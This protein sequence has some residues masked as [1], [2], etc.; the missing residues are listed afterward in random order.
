VSLVANAEGAQINES[1]NIKYKNVVYDAYFHLALTLEGVEEVEGDNNDV[2]IAV[3]KTGTSPANGDEPL[4]LSLKEYKDGNL[5]YYVTQGIAAKDI[6]VQISI[7]PVVVT[8]SGNVYGNCLEY[9]IAAYCQE[10]IDNDTIS[11]EQEALYNAT[12]AY[13]EAANAI[14]N[15]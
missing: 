2:G 12:I 5:T 9:S 7:Y 10:R 8:E 14:F 13:G 11:P 4:Y 3:F 6:S 15:K 1:Y